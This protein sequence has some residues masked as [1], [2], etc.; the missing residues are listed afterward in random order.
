[1]TKIRLRLHH[2]K[3]GNTTNLGNTNVKLRELR[4]FSSI[5]NIELNLGE[6]EWERVYF[7][8]VDGDSASLEWDRGESFQYLPDFLVLR[9]F[10]STF[11]SS[12][13]NWQ[14][15]VFY[16]LKRQPHKMVKHTQAIRR[17]LSTICLSVFDHFVWLALKGLVSVAW[18]CCL[19]MKGFVTD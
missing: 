16:L 13:S 4:S 19:G 1:M 9:F 18:V 15:L 6:F 8:L 3:L 17:P 5:P 7:Y 10:L 2:V 12:F 11:L 14:H